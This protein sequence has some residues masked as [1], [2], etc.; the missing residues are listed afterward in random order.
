[1]KVEGIETAESP[2]SAHN[3]FLPCVAKRGAGMRRKPI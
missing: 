3:I 2:I 1:M